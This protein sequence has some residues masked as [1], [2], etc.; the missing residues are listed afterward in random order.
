MSEA[1]EKKLKTL[2]IDEEL[3]RKYKTLCS[4]NGLSIMEVTQEIIQAWVKRE[5]AAT[6]KKH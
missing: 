5:E 2:K 1:T 4:N 3:H 6:K